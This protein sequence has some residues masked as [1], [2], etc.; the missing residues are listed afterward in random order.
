MTAV[1]PFERAGLGAAPF[2]CAGSYEAKYQ[3]CHGA[4]I[5]P[6]ASCD[7]CGQG[8]MLVYVIKSSDGKTFRVGCDCV[9]KTA[10]ACAKTDLERAARLVVDQVNKIRTAA[11]NARKDELISSAISKM[12]ANR[13][14]LAE[15]LVW[16]GYRD[17][18]AIHR[19]EWL[20]RHAG[21]SGK[22]KA[23][24][25]LDELLKDEPRGGEA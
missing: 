10:R 9:A 12:E 18:N 2:R 4:P 7:Y 19:L 6:G 25:Q 21:R 16:D 15:M 11:A 17:R 20:F 22:I 3:A 1:H 5:Q 14:R 8:I 24:K 23:A 13:G